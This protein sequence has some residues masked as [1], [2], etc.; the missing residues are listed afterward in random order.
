VGCHPP[1]QPAGE[2]RG[3]VTQ[4][5]AAYHAALQAGE[6]PNVARL[7]GPSLFMADER[8]SGG[9]DRVNAQEEELVWFLGRT[10]GQWRIVGLIVRD[11]QLPKER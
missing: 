5:L 3:A 9:S 11:I 10:S 6:A 2:D 1:A 4:V 7:L 8:T